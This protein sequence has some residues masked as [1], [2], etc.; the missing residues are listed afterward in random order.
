[1]SVPHRIAL[2]TG[3]GRGIGR[4]CAERLARAG[5]LVVVGGRSQPH[6]GETVQAIHGSGGQARAVPLDVAEE[7]SVREAFATARALGPIAVLVNNAGIALSAPLHKTSLA[8]FE[9]TLAVN[10]TGAFLCT[11]EA[12]PDMLAAGSGRVINIASTA[13]RIGF[14]YTAAYCAS[15]H[16]L[17]G[18]TRALALEVAKKGITVNAVCPGWTDTEML[19]ASVETIHGA[20]GASR[21]D[22]RETLAKMNPMGRIISPAEVAELVAYLAS[23]AAAAVT[24]QTLGIDGGE[25][26]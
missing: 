14:R 22:A 16:G 26:M 25:A 19:S 5:F 11:R 10:L 3:G 15:K 17:L 23:E 20:T 12:L 1:V 2:I 21:E 4:A 9:R 18:L 13:A 24:G 6:L 8:D 7:R